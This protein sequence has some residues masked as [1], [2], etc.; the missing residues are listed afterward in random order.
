MNTIAVAW[1]AVMEFGMMLTNIT[2]EV[3]AAEVAHG[4]QA[5]GEPSGSSG[6]LVRQE[7]VRAAPV[8]KPLHPLALLHVSVP[9]YP[10][11]HWQSG[12]PLALGGHVAARLQLLM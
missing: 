2:G 11:S 9:E 12:S 4:H 10:A 8:H 5:V 7:Y 3:T 1:L 6:V